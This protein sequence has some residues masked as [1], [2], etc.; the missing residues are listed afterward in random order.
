MVLTL[1]G[2]N[3]KCKPA[4]WPKAS[5]PISTTARDV[6]PY[7][8]AGTWTRDNYGPFWDPGPKAPR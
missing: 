2:E 5:S 8:E 3:E 6:F 7:F 1:A 4:A